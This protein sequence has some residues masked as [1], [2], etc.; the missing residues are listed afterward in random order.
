MAVDYEKEF[1]I[2]AELTAEVSTQIRK[3]GILIDQAIVAATPFDT[4]RAKSNWLMGINTPPSGTNESNIDKTGSYALE[5][6]NSV[7][8]QY[9]DN[10]LPPLWIVNNLPYIQR[11]NE[12]WSAQ[13]G[14]K[15]IEQAINQVVS[16]AK[17]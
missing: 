7:A 4:G 12:G 16:N 5:L 2:A 17:L 8:A 10:E 3:L 11:L 15:Y 13:A 14:T 6:A 1:S 9:P